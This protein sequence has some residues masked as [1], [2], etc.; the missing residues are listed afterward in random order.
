MRFKKIDSN[1]FIQNRQRFARQMRSDSLAI[2]QTNDK[3]PR[4]G[5]QYFPFRQ[6][7]DFFYLTG[8]DQPESVLL[9]YP[10]ASKEDQKE[11]LFIK[12]GDA[13]SQIWEGQRYTKKEA[14]DISGIQKVMWLQQLPGIQQNL[15]HQAKRIYVNENENLSVQAEI[16]TR[17]IRIAKEI[18]ERYPFHKYHRSQPILRYLRMIKSH[19]EI[20]LINHAAGITSQAFHR[21]LKAVKPGMKEYEIEAE[22]IHTFIAHGSAGHAYDPI[23]ASGASSCVLHYIKND[24]VCDNGDILLLDFGAEYGHYAADLSRTIPVNGKFTSRQR[25]VYQAVLRVL[26]QTIELMVPGMTLDELNK[27]VGLMI[28]HE[29]V[30]L[31]LIDRKDLKEKGEYAAYRQYFMHGVAHHLGLDVHDLSDRN[32]PFQAGM[33]LTCEPGIYIA[34]ESLGI[35]LENNIL[36]TDNGPVDLM[37]EIPIEVDHIESLMQEMVLN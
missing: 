23:V 22:I 6:N 9:L 15:I 20:E 24:Q 21:V 1:L 27:E 4:N 14:R 18:R 10:D 7:S 5:D 25:D 17:D 11:I 29:L 2:F 34:E 12:K 28:S 36:I 13:L 32:S 19:P 16:Q 8:I 30:A 31:D 35:R 37:A 3:M 33:I 26:K